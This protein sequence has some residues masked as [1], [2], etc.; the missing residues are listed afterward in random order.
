VTGAEFD[1]AYWRNVERFGKTCDNC[2]RAI[3]ADSG[4]STGWTHDG[5]WQGVRC[6]TMICG[7]TPAGKGAR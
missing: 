6:P 2:G 4:S 5:T 1:D 3:K 7:A